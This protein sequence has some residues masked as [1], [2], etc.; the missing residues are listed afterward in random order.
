MAQR[1]VGLQQ[2][3]GQLRGFASSAIKMPKFGSPLKSAAA[4]GVP[5]KPPAD[6]RRAQE[7]AYSHDLQEYNRTLKEVR[8]RYIE[9]HWNL[10][11]KFYD[12]RLREWI[13]QRAA[14]DEARRKRSIKTAA[15]VAKS[16]QRARF[17]QQVAHKLSEQRRETR[18]RQRE[19]ELTVHRLMI[20]EMQT[21]SHLAVIKENIDTSIH[22]GL[23]EFKVDVPGLPPHRSDYEEKMLYYFSQLDN[24]ELRDLPFHVQEDLGIVTE[25]AWRRILV[26]GGP[27]PT[28][29]NVAAVVEEA[30][31]S[32]ETDAPA[33]EATSASE[34][35]AEV[36]ELSESAKRAERDEARKKS[37][38][39][40][41]FRATEVK[42]FVES[43]M[44]EDNMK[45]P[46]NSESMLLAPKI[47]GKPSP[48]QEAMLADVLPPAGTEE[49][50]FGRE[51]FTLDALKK[52]GLRPITD[53]MTRFNLWYQYQQYLEAPEAKKVSLYTKFLN[54]MLRV[55]E[56]PFQLLESD[57][58][59]LEAAKKRLHQTQ[60]EVQV[61]ALHH[62]SIT[63]PTEGADV[64]APADTKTESATAGSEA[65]QEMDSRWSQLE[66]DMVNFQKQVSADTPADSGVAD[67]AAAQLLRDTAVQERVAVFG[68]QLRTKSMAQRLL[69]KDATWANV[70][71]SLRVEQA[72]QGAINLDDTSASQVR[73]KAVSSVV[74]D[75]EEA[76]VRLKEHVDTE[77]G[78]QDKASAT[79]RKLERRLAL[80]REAYMEQKLFKERQAANDKKDK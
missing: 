38:S 67:E 44:M 1:L 26:E 40:A 72:R 17:L 66:K 69:V 42:I 59:Q 41:A 9:Q 21:E 14:I 46:F 63:K 29:V 76:S 32:E 10:M 3:I 58:E 5:I 34:D 54:D 4:L 56:I 12:R 49:K 13:E 57:V 28:D 18:K 20:E 30:T 64:K 22:P 27:A 8:K 53:E 35:K 50:W 37:N 15:R 79:L 75:A 52:A 78:K 33:V 65:Q 39:E 31:T 11:E 16:M 80:E 62:H 6:T 61:V 60:L 55:Q 24:P 7:S 2:G 77:I 19:Y 74:R 70:A 23:F 73:Q 47:S 71:R 51:D 43:K 25:T 48:R 68:N 45:Q 36:K